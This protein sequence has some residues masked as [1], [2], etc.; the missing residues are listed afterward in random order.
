MAAAATTWP[1]MLALA[2]YVCKLHGATT[3]RVELVA[4][5]ARVGSGGCLLSSEVPSKADKI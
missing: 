5:R 4:G 1:F 2:T 3:I